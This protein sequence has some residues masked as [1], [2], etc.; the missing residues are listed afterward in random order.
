MHFKIADFSGGALSFE[1]C[2]TRDEIHR[3]R[4]SPENRDLNLFYGGSNAGIKQ[5]PWHAALVVENI[6]SCGGT[7]ISKTAVLT[8]PKNST[9]SM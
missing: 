9:P 5:H 7:L 4:R 6:Q 2:G 1:N 3:R 8:G